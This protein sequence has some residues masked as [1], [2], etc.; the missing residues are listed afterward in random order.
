MRYLILDK[1]LL[2]EVNSQTLVSLV[3]PSLTSFLLK[4][5]Q[6]GLTPI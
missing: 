2:L 6:R 5:L 3:D 1:Q 4:L